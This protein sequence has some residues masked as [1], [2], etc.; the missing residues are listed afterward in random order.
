[1]VASIAALLLATGDPQ[2]AP[3]YHAKLD[4]V[5]SLRGAWH[6]VA[7]DDASGA[8]YALAWRGKAVEVDATGSVVRELTLPGVQGSTLRLAH[9][10]AGGQV[11]LLAFR[12]WSDQVKAY[13]LAG[14]ELWTY[15]GGRS[16]GIDDVWPA[17]LDGDG[18]DET[19]VGFNGRG[20]HALD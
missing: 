17:D 16:D 12:V 11:A 4:P 15:P 1:M 2:V 14:K 3:E 20:V 19:I 13:D 7:T 5:W 6:G 9:L 18:T 8:I 10:G